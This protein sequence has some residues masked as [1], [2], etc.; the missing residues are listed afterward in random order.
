MAKRDPSNKTRM[1][2]IGGGGAGM[3]CA[4]TLRQSGFTGEITV[5]SN[6]P[7]LPYD[8]TI[9][10]KGLA[11]TDSSKLSLRNSEFVKEHGIDFVLG[12]SAKSIDRSSRAVLLEN[13]DKIHYDKLL[14]ATGGRARVPTNQGSNLENVFLLRSAKD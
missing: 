13:G 3:N 2:I 1:V 7:V 14:L 10:S 5:V 9:L 6:E 4:E 12:S 11:T 8:R